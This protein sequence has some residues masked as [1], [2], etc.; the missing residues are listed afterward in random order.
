MSFYQINPS[1]IDWNSENS[2]VFF[3][4]RHRRKTLCLNSIPRL[5]LLK[6]HIWLATSGRFYQKWV[7]L[8]KS[9]VLFSA[10]AVNQH[11]LVTSKDRWGVCLPLFHIGGLSILARTHISGS[12][13]FLYNKKWSAKDFLS[14]LKERKITIT[15]LVPTQVYD[16]VK[17]RLAC[18]PSLRAVV[19]GGA[20]ISKNLYQEA[21]S[22]GWPLLPSYGLTE[23]GS[24]V[25][26]ASLDS[27][28]Q[29]GYPRLKVLPHVK[30]KTVSGK[31]IIQSRS[32]LTGFI[33][34]FEKASFQDPKKEDWYYTE[35]KG[36]LIKG[37]LEIDNSPTDTIKILGEKVNLQDLREEL[38]NILLKTKN[39]S[40]RYF[41]FSV[42]NERSGF[43][44]ALISDVL[45]DQTPQII[46]LFNKKVSSFEKIQQFYFMPS[47]P[48]TDISKISQ[49]ALLEKIGFCD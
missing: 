15:S 13:Y 38:M 48:L 24:Q 6:A 30:L 23:C 9:A 20:Y 40:G 14:Y 19:V 12:A 35:D 11:L 17:A 3:N 45:N 32:L 10:E 21:R 34:L 25:A 46:S 5:P 16:L 7:A 36:T 27:L 47:L 42:P 22:L 49:A 33:P 28:D 39:V 4:E 44:V 37:F 29:I 18:P 1:K 8:S 41:L 26:T 2:F 43:Q 31:I